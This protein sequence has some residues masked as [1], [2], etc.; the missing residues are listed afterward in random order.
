MCVLYCYYSLH[1]ITT[2]LYVAMCSENGSSRIFP[3]MRIQ[4]FLCAENDV[5][6]FESREFGVHVDSIL[7]ALFIFFFLRSL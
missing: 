1:R 3:V 4:N 6:S 5:K 2:M 7:I